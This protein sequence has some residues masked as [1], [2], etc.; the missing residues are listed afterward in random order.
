MLLILVFH[1][2]SHSPWIRHVECRCSLLSRSPADC[3]AFALSLRQRPSASPSPQPCREKSTY[4]TQPPAYLCTF[5]VPRLRSVASHTGE[6][7]ERP[8]G[9]TGLGKGCTGPAGG[10][11][12]SAR[13][14]TLKVGR[15]GSSSAP[16]SAVT[17]QEPQ[18]WCV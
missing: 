11:A 8:R 1:S 9:K 2:E 13:R 17:P 6:H 18:L 10:T 3:I 16:L 4:R 12:G 15:T 14:H 7:N 5:A